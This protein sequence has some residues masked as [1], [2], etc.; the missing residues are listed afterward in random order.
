MTNIGILDPTGINK[1]PLTNE[2]YSDR[3]RELGKIWSNFPAYK[4]ADDILKTLNENQVTIITS[5]TGSGKTVLIPKFLLHIFGYEKNIAVTLPKQI[6]V[7]STAEFSAETLD[8]KLGQHVGYQ[9][10]GSDR[11]HMNKD[12]KLIYITDGSLV[13]RL[14]NDITLE[15][16][17]GVI[18]DE[19]H[20]RNVRIDFLLYLTKEVLTRRPDFKLIIMSATIDT[21]LFNNYY[22]DFKSSVMNISGETLYPIKSHYLDFAISEKDYVK[23]GLAI[24]NKIIEDTEDGDILFFVT[25]INETM[26]VCKKFVHDKK[27]ICLEVYSGIPSDKQTLVE[28]ISKYKDG[29][30]YTRKV[31][32]ATNAAE[33]SLT[34]DGIKY[35]IE[36]G[37]ELSSYFDP[38]TGANRLD[39]QRITKAQARQRMGRSGRTGPGICHHL[40]TKAEYEKM[41]DFPEPEIRTSDITSECLRLLNTSYIGTVDKL[42]KVLTKFIEPPKEKYIQ[43]AVKKMEGLKLIKSGRLTELG[44]IINDLRVTMPEL[45][46]ALVYAY[47]LGVVF[48]VSKVISILETTRFNISDLFST[49]LDKVQNEDPDKRKKM[50]SKLMDKFSEKK[51]KLASSTGDH[52]SLLKIYDRYRKATDKNV[53]DFV[54][55]YWLKLRKLGNIKKS[56]MRL[57]GNIMKTLMKNKYLDDQMSDFSHLKNASDKDKI[58]MS[59]YKG[60]YMNVGKLVNGTEKYK[61]ESSSSQDNSMYGIAK[62]SFLHYS[63]KLPQTVFY[64]ELFITMGTGSLNMVSTISDKDAKGIISLNIKDNNDT[65]NIKDSD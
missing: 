16:I 54:F 49:P 21:N 59:F 4:R 29:T 17:S 20:E 9:Y 57:K 28:N 62:D 23:Y 26:D 51:G 50:M 27:N 55:E 63:K 52:I 12:S 15:G 22:K 10:K 13:A 2:D 38:E 34:I 6:I 39:R 44:K 65:K 48:D 14:M 45:G 7:K 53:N 33:S 42:I 24:I 5:G 56:N 18:I 11:K 40:Y 36:S 8:V 1:N 43:V 25:S 30:E 41:K 3:Y 60:F 35:V 32:V 37:Y 64:G 47:M 46:V 31:I 58:I 19:A 61:I